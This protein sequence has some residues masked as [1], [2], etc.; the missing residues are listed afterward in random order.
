MN[1][2]D[3]SLLDDVGQNAVNDYTTILNNLHCLKTQTS[4][5]VKQIKALEKKNNKQMKALKK[6]LKKYL[7]QEF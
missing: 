7:M 1:G 5:V 3:N 4:M 2:I 6:E